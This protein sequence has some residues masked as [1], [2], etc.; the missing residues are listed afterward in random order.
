MLNDVFNSDAFKMTNM[1]SAVNKVPA[2]PGRAG[3]LGLFNERGVTTTSVFIEEQSGV[4]S[5]IPTKIRGEAPNQNKSGKR[6]VRSLIIP[7]LPLEDSLLAAEIQ[8]VRV[9]GGTELQGLEAKRDEKLAG[10]ITKHDATLEY[11]RIGALKGIIYDADGSTVIYNL[12]TEFGVTQSTVDFVLG[13][14]TT[15]IKTKCTA[16]KRLIEAELGG[17]VYEHIHCFAG[18][19]WFDDFVTHPKVEAAYALWQDGQALRSDNRSGFEF[20]GIVF[21]EYVGAIGGVSFVADSECHFFP[22]GITGLYQTVFAPG[23]FIEAANTVG[24]PRYAK[25]EPMPYGRGINMLTE[26]N[27][28]SICNRPK[29]LVKGTTS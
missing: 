27:P 1:M 14:A 29:V 25:S 12:F 2:V 9:F 22:V 23:D 21:E 10:M 17:L 28:L 5:L 8:G 6:T 13:T 26:S 15:A 20:C 16:V 3:R 11:G 24:L 18:K 4:L 7:H 19:T